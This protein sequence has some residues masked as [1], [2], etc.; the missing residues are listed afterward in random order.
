[1]K[2]TI[3][4][5]L[6]S[7]FIVITI[8]SSS[9]LSADAVSKKDNVFYSLKND[10]GLSTAAACGIM[11]NIERESEFDSRNVHI[12]SN[13]LLSGG[14]CMWNGGRFRSL[15]NFC[16]NNG[17]DYLSVEG[18]IEYLKHELSS[19][20]YKHIYNYLKN[21]SNNSSGAYDAAY[22]WCYYFEIP[23]NRSSAA[24]GRG[25]LASSSYWPS[26]SKKAEALNKPKIS[27]S[28]N[29]KSLDFKES[30]VKVS[31]TDAGQSCTGYT[32]QIAKKGSNGKYNWKNAKSISLSAKTK[33][34]TYNLSKYGVGTFKVRVI[35]KNS[36]KTVSSETISYKAV[37]KNHIYKTKVITRPTANKSGLRTYTCAKCGNVL[38]QKAPSLSSKQG[39]RPTS[40]A[41]V[42]FTSTKT[43]VTITVP[44][45]NN[46][47]GYIIYKYIDKE[48]KPYAALTQNGGK[49]KISSLSAGKTYIYKITAF[50]DVSGKAL[51]AKKS[52]VIKVATVPNEPK[53]TSVSAGAGSAKVNWKAVSGAEA[54]AVY[55][56]K[57]GD[58][59]YTKYGVFDKLT[60]VKVKGLKRKKKYYFRVKAINRG[61]NNA[62]SPSSNCVSAVIK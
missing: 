35:A 47:S 2:K 48:Y 33:S 13:G 43:S 23:A 59:A 56:K 5:F 36:S 37:C 10:L 49:V 9:A 28:A 1:M 15:K 55:Y 46:I 20:Y 3:S 62:Y 29:S 18:Q 14:L 19:S 42:S 27:S 22:Y 38:K 41:K 44:K 40:T 21:V 11:A 53:I 30:K 58:S 32:V 60:S 4:A 34:Y 39:V 50:T 61:N 7:V 45:A 17:Y 6:M 52:K 12:D 16:N 24:H 31:W 8:L 57:D 25:S 51:L 54:Y 26:Y